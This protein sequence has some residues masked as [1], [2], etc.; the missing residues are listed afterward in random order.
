MNPELTIGIIVL[1]Q[2]ILSE[3]EAVHDKHVIEESTMTGQLFSAEIECRQHHNRQWHKWDAITW[4]G[5]YVTMA[6]AASA[7]I[8][9]LTGLAWRFS[10]FPIALNLLRNKKASYLGKGVI[11]S[12][13]NKTL[14]PLGTLIIKIIIILT[15]ISYA[16]YEVLQGIL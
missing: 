11:D 16:I 9:I 6:I 15:L 12:F 2:G 14:K 8:L 7:P 5:I 13:C 4:T 10:F 1:A 3:W